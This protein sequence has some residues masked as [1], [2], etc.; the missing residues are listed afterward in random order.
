MAAD[1]WAAR[2]LATSDLSDNQ[3]GMGRELFVS[4]RQN[5]LTA[6]EGASIFGIAAQPAAPAAA[7]DTTT[8]EA[9]A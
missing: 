2:T 8:K 6:E 9:I 7:N 4:A 5:A 3:F 1:Q